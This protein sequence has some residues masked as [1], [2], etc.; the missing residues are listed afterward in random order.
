MTVRLARRAGR[1]LWPV[2]RPALLPVQFAALLFTFRLGR[3]RA[4]RARGDRGAISIELALAII[5]LVAVAGAVATALY[6]LKDKVVKKVEQDPNMPGGGGGAGG[7]T[8]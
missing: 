7:A 5:A 3:L 2:L 4:A 1:L 8:P 6:L